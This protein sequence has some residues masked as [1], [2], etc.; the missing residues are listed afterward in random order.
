MTVEYVDGWY[1]IEHCPPEEIWAGYSEEWN[2]K[3]RRNWCRETFEKGTWEIRDPIY[4]YSIGPNGPGKR[5]LGTTPL[6]WR[7]K[8]EADA[9]LFMLRWK[10]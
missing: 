8:R 2:W 5:I 6:T 9:T 7:F 3:P 1:E 10:T 4:H